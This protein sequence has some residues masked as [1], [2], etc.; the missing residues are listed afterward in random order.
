MAG[1]Y[2]FLHDQISY[3]VSPEYFTCFK[4]QQFKIP[5]SLHSRLGAG[6]V[7]IKATWWMGIVIGIIIIPIGLIIPG[8]K[9]Y[10]KVMMLTFSCAC[11]TALLTGII[12]LIYG[13]S[14]YSATNL[15]RFNVPNEVVDKISFC[16]VG[17]MHNLSYI[18]GLL[19]IFVG[20]VFIIVANFRVR[21]MI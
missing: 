4:F 12:A 19:G 13:L 14:N 3:T 1:I 20:V 9:N 10:F 8:W 18:G 17:N 15:P 21:K 7:G 2:G 11:V 16:V 5:D 6:I